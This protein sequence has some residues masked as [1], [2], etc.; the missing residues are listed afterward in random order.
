MT[1]AGVSLWPAT[2]LLWSWALPSKLQTP[3][4]TTHETR[5]ELHTTFLSTQDLRSE[6]QMALLTTQEIHSAL[7]SVSL[8]TQEVHSEFQ[9]AFMTTQEVHLDVQMSFRLPD[10][11]LVRAPDDPGVTRYVSFKEWCHDLKRTGYSIGRRL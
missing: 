11:Q 8:T 6:L 4:L 7:Q 10:R 9:T 3:Y 1:A 5:S 2:L